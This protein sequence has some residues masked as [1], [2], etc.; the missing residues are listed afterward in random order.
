MQRVNPGEILLV[1]DRECPVCE[2]Y[3]RMAT[4]RDSAGTLR[5]VN[6]RDPSAIMREIT[7]AGLDI[8]EGLV[9]K[10]GDTLYYGADAIHVLALLSNQAGLLIRLASWM[11][12]SRNFSGILYPW[13]RS[14]R[15]LL[16]K[17][18]RKSRINN[19]GLPG[20]DRF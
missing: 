12:R 10:A 15:N 17:I 16:L 18:L 2:A 9:L 19:L 13:F 14:L 7:A 1:Y 11:F 20:R 6:A 8:D 5:R 4:I 3:C